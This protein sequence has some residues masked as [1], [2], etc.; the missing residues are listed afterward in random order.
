MPGMP[1][2][3]MGNPPP[4]QMA[5]FGSFNPMASFNNLPSG[6]VLAGAVG[7]GIVGDPNKKPPNQQQMSNTTNN[8]NKQIPETN[9]QQH[10][11]QKGKNKP[12]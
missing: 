8:S 7:A 12:M 10:N 3:S 2:P 11:D 5:N 4:S 1:H 6:N 9:D